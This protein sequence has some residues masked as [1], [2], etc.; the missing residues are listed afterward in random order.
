M[1]I[2]HYISAAMLA[3]VGLGFTACD[4]KEE[5]GY[6]PAATP[7]DAERV[8]FAQTRIS[9][10]VTADETEVLVPVYRPES[11]SDSELT[12]QILASFAQEGDDQIFHVAPDVTFEANQ[13][14]AQIAVT[15]DATAM[16]PNTPYAISIAISE[17]NADVYGI[18]STELVLNYEVMTDWALFKGTTEEQDGY[19]SWT[20]GS[21]FQEVTFSPARV[22]ERHVPSDPN[23]IEFVLQ[24]YDGDEEDES[25]IPHDEDFNNPEWLDIWT[26]STVDGGKTIVLP[27]QEFILADGISCAEASLLYPNSFKNESSFDPVSGIFTFN[28]MCFDE[29]GAW[30]PAHWYI[31][32]YGYADTNVYTLDV[33]DKGQINVGDVDYAVI[34]FRLSETLSFVNYT[35]VEL[36]EDSAGLTEEEVEEVAANLDLG[37]KSEYTVH[38]LTKSGNVTMT[39]PASGTYEVVAVGYNKAADGTSEGKITATCVFTFE[40]F[41]PYAGWTTI[42]ENALFVNS[43]FS[44]FI[45][46]DLTETLT[47]EV[48]MSDE[49]EGLYRIVNPFASSPYVEAIGLGRDKF[50]SIE[51]AEIED[52]VVY[53]PIAET[54]LIL[55]GKSLGL[56]SYSYYLLANGLAYEQIPQQLFGTFS[57]NKVEFPAS[58]LVDADG[59]EITNFLMSLDGVPSY[60]ANFDFSLDL[61]G[62]EAAAAPVR[63]VAKD[64]AKL[65][66]K[67]LH[68]NVKAIV[69]PARYKASFNA[70]K[71]STKAGKLAIVAK[72][73]RR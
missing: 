54:G 61:N 63:K 18:A 72:S 36:P 28:V 47:V 40:T 46:E 6:T 38:T 4:G 26:F 1:N 13:A 33:N 65:T 66:S 42:T 14:F 57:N 50:G 37:D 35:V 55:N 19:G 44:C 31:S 49:F 9:K 20:I 58:T 25:L 56:L 71:T 2:K 69:F 12:V 73:R 7:S 52:G 3:L 62:G 29:E 53:F 32:L 15:Y 21:P 24:V 70:A 43:L 39:F 68:S 67:A 27:V 5:P 64:M 10:T 23:Q 11:D 8:Y 22:F 45:G 60:Y 16:T 41:D 59:D 17:A 34:D 30:N 48:Q 51:F